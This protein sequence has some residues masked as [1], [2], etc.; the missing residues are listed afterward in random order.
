MLPSSPR[1]IHV[2]GCTFCTFDP[3]PDAIVASAGEDIIISSMPLLMA[4]GRNRPY[5][6]GTSSMPTVL[7]VLYVLVVH[8]LA[9]L[10]Y[11]RAF[12]PAL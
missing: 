10:A 3:D 1:D 5:L 6:Y 2:G 4:D 12:V 8:D 9:V 11:N 7:Q